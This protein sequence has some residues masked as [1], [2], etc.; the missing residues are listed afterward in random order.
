MEINF[1]KSKCVSFLK[2]IFFH[3]VGNYVRPLF[4]ESVFIIMR[5]SFIL[6]NYIAISPKAKK[7]RPRPDSRKKELKRNLL[8]R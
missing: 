6:A 7:G 1:S 2:Q 3:F 8:K 4:I 5:S